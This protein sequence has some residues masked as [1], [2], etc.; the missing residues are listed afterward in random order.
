MPILIV[1]HIH[2]YLS[3][4]KKVLESE[5]NR[6]NQR[7]VTSGKNDVWKYRDTPPSDWNKP[8]PQWFQDKNKNY[9]MI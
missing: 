2:S 9:E 3:R 7:L 6:I 4:Q 8:L 1:Y 5:K